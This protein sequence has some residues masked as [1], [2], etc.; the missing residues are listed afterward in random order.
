MKLLRRHGWLIGLLLLL[1]RP[2]TVQATPLPPLTALGIEQGLSNNTVRCIFRDH[3]GLVWLGTFDGLNRYDGY[4]FKVYRHRTGDSNSLVHNIIASITEDSLHNLWIGTRQGISKLNT[5]SGRFTTIRWQRSPDQPVQALNAVVKD[6]RADRPGNVFV[7]SEGTGLL[8]IPKGATTATAV[9]LVTNTGTITQYAVRAIRVDEAGNAWALVHKYGIALYNARTQQLQLVSSTMTE[10]TAMELRGDHLWI[11]SGSSIYLYRPSSGITTVV[12]DG[13][14]AP[15]TNGAINTFAIDAA[16]C[17]WIGTTTGKLFTWQPGRTGFEVPANGK[18]AEEMTGGTIYAVFIDQQS[19]KWLG[20]ARAGVN[21]IDPQKGHFLTVSHEPGI[22]NSLVDN[23]VSALYEA[24]G[25]KL[26]IG[27]DGGGLNSWDRHTNTFQHYRNEP[28]NPASLSHNAVVAIKQDHTGATWI[29]TFGVGVNRFEAATGRFTAYPLLNSVSDRYNKVA[30]SLLED[31][32]QSLW[33]STL[34]QGSE[35]GALYRYNRAADRFDVFDASLSDLFALYED[36]L[37]NLWGGNLT[38]LVKIDRVNKQHV[39]YNIGYAVKCIYEDSRGDLWIGTEGGGLQRFDRNKKAVTAI[40]TTGEGLCS[41]VVLT[42][43]EDEKAQLWLSTFNGLSR[44]NAAQKTF[45]NY[46]QADGLQSNQFHYNSALMLSSGE[47]VFGGI[48]GFS[49]F[50]PDEITGSHV[51]PPLLLTDLY[52][53]N[54]P[55]EKAPQFITAAEGTQVQTIRVPYD[56]AIFSFHFTAVEYTVPGKI[57]YA[58]FMEGWDRGWNYTGNLRSA[59]YTHLDEGTYT[60]RV[61]S[62]NGDGDWNPRELA[63]QVIVLPPWY[64]SWWAYSLYVLAAAGAIYLF[65]Y[66]KTRQNRLHYDVKVAQLAARESQLT[67]QQEKAVHEKRLAFFTNVSHEFRTPL[68]LIIDPVKEMMAAETAGAQQEG[69]HMVYRNA[70]RLLSLVDQLLL[71][72]KAETHSDSLHLTELDAT[73]LCKEVFFSF[74]QQARI[75][76]INYRF[77][78]GEA[79]VMLSAD[80]DKLE[81]ILFNLLSNAMKFTPAGGR[82]SLQL[83]EAADELSIRVSDTGPGIPPEV[84]DKL[85]NSFYQ[86][87]EGQSAGKTGFGIGLYL[88]RHFTVLHHGSLQYTSEAGKGT[89]FTLSLLKGQAHFAGMEIVRDQPAAP[90]FLEEL[91]PA[92]LEETPK[93]KSQEMVTLVSEKPTILVVDDDEELRKYISQA[94]SKDFSILEAANGRIGVDLAQQY[95][96]DLIISDITMEEL[97]GLELCRQVKDNTSLS[98][99]PVILLTASTAS[100]TRLKGIEAGADDYITKPFEKELLKARVVSLLKKRNTL[101]QYF[102][103]EITLQ[104]N[105]QKVSVEYREFLE[106]CIKVV[107]DHLDDETFSIKTLSTEMGMSRSSLYRKVNSVSGQSI[108]GFIRFIRLRKAAGLMINTENNI[109]EIAS[110]TGFNDIKYFRTHFQQLFGMNPS[111]YIKRFRKPFH[112]N[113]QLN[114]HV[115]KPD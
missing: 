19:R 31:R 49:L 32:N 76:K 14:S 47:L 35:Y 51:M 64:R 27:T 37:G 1:W 115:I 86:V 72:R 8:L 60:F 48:K 69:L 39:F 12:A 102:Y 106:R 29:T 70:R 61:K 80:R 43:L 30:Y 68:T 108:V 21:I 18:Y 104:Q 11:S 25:G 62:T 7:A 58:Y 107:E 74:D 90:A 77:E 24:P 53:N 33:V 95:L 97:G 36:R 41:D 46:Y 13:S 91:R 81:I 109:N 10:A 17:F 79:P 15:P 114:K 87:R 54:Q 73:E 3:R 6:I 99:I 26:Y 89:C 23:A 16:N 88:A 112:N 75:K 52:I 40:Y 65:L 100:E 96:P 66:Y 84:G 103:N 98:H 4:D 92:A 42:I 78:A 111:E 45:K 93:E 50:K 71:F 22:A 56:E 67:A 83:V 82:I 28:G 9:P 101:Q 5:L 110:I 57:N 44:F 34:R 113:L 20:T 59:T 38:Q 94:F 105:D 2:V 85:F 63:I 55:I